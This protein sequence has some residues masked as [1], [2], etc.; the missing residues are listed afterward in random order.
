MTTPTAPVPTIDPEGTNEENTIRM[1][2]ILDRGT[3]SEVIQ[4]V[5]A[6]LLVARPDLAVYATTLDLLTRR[7][8]TLAPDGRVGGFLRR[9]PILGSLFRR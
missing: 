2:E 7:I 3:E 9:I 1:V 5:K 4:A 6:L 8:P